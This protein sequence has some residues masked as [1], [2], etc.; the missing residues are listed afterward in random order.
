MQ[1]E[2]MGKSYNDDRGTDRT[3]Q[4]DRDNDRSGYEENF[5]IH[6]RN[7]GNRRQRRVFNGGA[8]KEI[9][10]TVSELSEIAKQNAATTQEVCTAPIP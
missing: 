8:R 7:A 5:R 1:Y 3:Y 10:E 4:R 6:R 2:T 9:V